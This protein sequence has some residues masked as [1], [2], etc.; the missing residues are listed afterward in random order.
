[1]L[2]K[3]GT[4]TSAA[5]L[6]LD[7]KIECDALTK[8]D[9]ACIAAVGARSLAP[10]SMV[11]GVP[12]G[13]LPLAKALEPYCSKSGRILIVDDVWTTGKS[14]QDF[15]NNHDGVDD[16]WFGFVAFARAPLPLFVTCFARLPD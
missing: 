9:W 10:F 5:G 7:W 4:F 15:A 1:M 14:M 13:G 2:F 11:L 12:R 8:D 16:W 6:E 3:W